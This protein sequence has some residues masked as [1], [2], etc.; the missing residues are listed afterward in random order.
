MDDYLF[1]PNGGANPNISG[2]FFDD[3]FNPNGATESDGNLANLG[4]TTAQGQ[5][6]SDAYWAHMNVVYAELLKRGKFSWQQLWTGQATCDYVNSYDCLGKTGTVL[7]VTKEKCAQNLRSLCSHDSPAQTRTMLFPFHTSDP[8]VLPDF[9][10]DLANFLL[11]RGP[12]AF[13]GHAWHG[14]RYVFFATT[15]L[16]GVYVCRAVNTTCHISPHADLLTLLCV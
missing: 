14:C 15:R 9:E 5:A 7:L 4:L 3:Q 10:E 16:L 6:L 2:F 13:L 11:V 8:A 12:Y 1:G